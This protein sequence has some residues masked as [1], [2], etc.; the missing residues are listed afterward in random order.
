[1]V[2]MG[3]IIGAACV[4]RGEGDA[5]EPL[6]V[7]DGFFLGAGVSKDS[8][9][10]LGPDGRR[11]SWSGDDGRVL[12]H[13]KTPSKNYYTSKYITNPLQSKKNLMHSKVRPGNVP[14]YF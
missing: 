5:P 2:G 11:V 3:N 4:A 14:C 10:P 9:K 13:S 12:R 6:A 1:M 8:D 7:G